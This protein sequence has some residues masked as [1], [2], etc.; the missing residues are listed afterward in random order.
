MRWEINVRVFA[1]ARYL[2]LNTPSNATN[3]LGAT[4]LIPVTIGVRW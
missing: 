2:F 1:E 4:E 3:G